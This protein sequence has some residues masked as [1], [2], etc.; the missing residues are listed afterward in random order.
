LA[1]ILGAIA[2]GAFAKSQRVQLPT[3]EGP[4]LAEFR[5]QTSTYGNVIPRIYGTMRQA[6]NV[7]WSTDI[8]E[9]RT[10]KTIQQ[11]SGGKGGG[12]RSTVSQTTTTYA[13]YVTLA[14][15]ICEGPVDEI[16][17]VWA[18]SKCLI[19]TVLASNKGKYNIHL[20]DEEQQPDDIIAK[21]KPAGSFPAYRGLAYVVIEDF[22][23]ADYGNRIPNF[24]FEVRRSVR[25]KPSVE[26]K[27][28]EIVMIPGSG[29]FVYSTSVCTKQEVIKLK[30]K[31]IPYKGRKSL[32]MHNYEGKA[33]V[34]LAI[35]Q[36]LKTLPN[37]EW[38]ALVVTWFATSTIAAKCEIIPK[39]EFH[40][41]TKIYPQEWSVAGYTRKTAKEVLRFN[42][43]TPTYG[44]TPSDNSILEV[45]KELKNRGIKV[46]LYPMLF[47]D[48]IK[49]VAK[50]WRGRIKPSSSDI[51][52]K[53]F[54]KTNGYNRFIIHYANLTKGQVDAFV[55]GSELVGMTSFREEYS[56]NFPAVN[57]LV[58][59]AAVVK[60]IV[61]A[62]TK[63]TYAADWSE[64]HHTEHGWY[65]LDPLWSSPNIDFVG[66]D[67]YFPLT[68]D[69]P[70][71]Q[72]TEAKIMEAWEKGEGWDYYCQDERLKKTKFQ[73]YNYAWKN[74]EHW[75][76][77]KH[78]NP[79]YQVTSWQP[80]MKPVW[81]CEI[82]FP[83]VD[84]CA[85]QPNVFYDPSSKESLF[86]RGS[87]S[88]INFQAQREALNASLDYLQTRNAMEDKA[89]LIPRSFIWCWDARPF[90]FWPDLE[91][92]WKDSMLWATGH[93]VNGKLGCSTLGAIVAELFQ[94]TGLAK[95]DYDVTRLTETV[96]GYIIL[97]PITARAALEQLA[98]AYFFDVV[99]SDGILK[100]V[101]R[102]NNSCLSISQEDLVPIN[103]NGVQD[104]L[105]IVRAQELELPQRVNVTYIDR[106][107]NYDPV[108]QSSQRQT[109][110]A[111][112]QVMLNLPL[113]MSSTMAKK[114]ADVTLYGAWKERVSFALTLPPKYARVEPTDI[115]TVTVADTTY[116]MRVVKT[117]MERNG[118]MKVA[119]VM[120]D[121]SSYD[122]HSNT[123]NAKSN[124][125][126][127]ELIPDTILELLDLP[128]LPTDL[129]NQACLR[130]AVA[131]N[132]DDWNGTAIYSSNNGGEKGDNNFAPLTEIDTTS[133]MGVII[134]DLA[135]APCATWD[136]NNTVEVVLFSGSLVS[137]SE[138]ALLNGANSAM[139]GG[140]LI[141]FQN[142]KV[143]GEQRYLLSR[144][145]RGRQ[146]TEH[147]IKTHESGT[148]FVLLDSS[149]YTASMPSNM[150]GRTIHY[151]AVTVG[152]ALS[153]TEE[154]AFTYHGNNLKPFAPVHITGKRDDSGSLIISWIRRSR[155]GS[156]WRDNV[157]IPLAEE[158]EKYQVDVLDGDTVVRTLEV[159]TPIV[160]YT[161]AEQLADFKA[162]PNNIAIR[163]YQMSAI[164]GRGHAATAT[165]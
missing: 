113:V 56:S 4:R 92:V 94:L 60:N 165:I 160:I 40:G 9:V 59:L 20:G 82:G 29:E 81:F 14:I 42:A 58:S 50:P 97:H 51:A 17:R 128:P 31:E 16:I 152:N 153:N 15:S 100:C 142:A 72:I 23:L 159:S 164:I 47:V 52:N 5:A 19:E 120:E 102:G 103:K 69:L 156:D 162:T 112:E 57:Q 144:L 117:D 7:I 147:A 93:W 66:I 39:V 122:F 101:L 67:A 158:S 106:P 6:G 54:T 1:L 161:A 38:V 25:F 33:D 109:V 45:I 49:P 135:S 157:D 41:N 155:V 61:G 74:L 18:D 114:I 22:P 127:P 119:A 48:Q 145:L 24:S 137:V 55:I 71:S 10:D 111:V 138:L 44:G 90:S 115:I 98:A 130:I 116:Q 37:I 143:I 46:M 139:I 148:R 11:Q 3:Q 32:N 123:G 141:Q 76:S 88:R 85:N 126:P 80:R 83:S 78:T 140:E 91:G 28:K 104:V 36:L 149:L 99:E 133:T 77:N 132:G 26:D 129:D 65:N 96:E 136:E 75:W 73:G 107:F 79:D 30:T 131:G 134:T 125:K 108:T 121:T 68:E 154:Q 105:E 43:H 62:S 95:S 63:I 64:Y 53:W 110:K 70:Q 86:P 118:L 13:Y 2:S 151:K 163:V 8:K 146:G 21:Y 124:A 150:I 27:I 35:D 84:A 34:I 87:R 12:G 89:D